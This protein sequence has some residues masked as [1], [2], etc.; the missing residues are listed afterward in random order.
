MLLEEVHEVKDAG[1]EANRFKELLDVLFVAYGSLGKM[2]LSPQDI[3]DGYGLL[4][5]SNEAKSAAKN[6]EGKVMKGDKFEKI[7]PKLQKLLDFRSK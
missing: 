6:A 2:G 4:V 1:N 5:S 7:E 3:V